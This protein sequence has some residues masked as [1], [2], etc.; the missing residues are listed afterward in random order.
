MFQ[1]SLAEI[2]LFTFL[3]LPS[4]FS[5]L[6]ILEPVFA[7]MNHS[8]GFFRL[9]ACRLNGFL[10]DTLIV[11]LQ[12]LLLFLSKRYTLI[13][14]P[15]LPIFACILCGF[16]Q[17][18]I[19]LDAFLYKGAKLRF[20]APFFAFANDLGCFWDSAKE[21]GI[22]L[23]Y[24]LGVIFFAFVP[25]GF[26]KIE[27]AAD[28][29]FINPT[30]FIWYSA[31][32]FL[33]VFCAIFLP[34]KLC[35]HL[36]NAFFAQLV[37]VLKKF[38]TLI[39]RKYSFTKAKNLS[40]K[41]IFTPQN[42]KYSSVSSLYPLLKYTNG[43]TGEKQCDVDVDTS[44]RPH[45]I[46]LFMES[47]RAKDVGV[48]QGEQSVTPHFD[49]LSKEGILFSNFYANSVKTSR[50][51]TAS[52]FGIPSDVNSSEISSRINM[53]FISL[54]HILEKSGYE[55]TYHHNGLLEFE[56]QQSFFTNYGYKNLVGR[57]DILKKYPN[58]QLT[59]W[60][61]HDEY[62]MKYS[63]DWLAEEDKK[64]KPVFLTMFTISNHHPWSSPK[65]YRLK[66]L[67]DKLDP[68]YKR[69]LTT[70]HYSDLCLKLFIDRLKKNNL[71][72]KTVLFIL[73]DH[74]HPMG[75]HNKN[76]IEQRYLYEE[77]IHVPLLIYA[78]GRI[79]EPKI[80]DD[81]SSQ[82]DLIPTVMDMLKI[83]GLNHARGST[84]LR[85]ANRQVF[86]HNPYVYRFYGTRKG[87]H[88]LIYTKSS[89][90]VELYDLITDPREQTNIAYKYP[91]I[92]ESYLEDVKNYH[93]YYQS[94][95]DNKLFSPFEMKHS[96]TVVDFSKMNR[97]SAARLLNELKK[98]PYILHLDLS[99]CDLL[100]DST[101]I[102]MIKK[103]KE[104]RSLN[105]SNCKNLTKASLDSVAS[106]C[107]RLQFIDLSFCTFTEKEIDFFIKKGE[108][109]ES[110]I[111]KDKDHLRSV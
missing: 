58:A 95:Y 78:E 2:L 45:V 57:N 67:P 66:H 98:H 42:E 99:S 37:W 30:F 20:E 86:F 97:L 91:E 43:F 101:F 44:D 49:A 80:I 19:L 90:E 94:L 7:K 26:Y 79:K 6:L 51:V 62:L 107:E 55:S 54:A 10:Q 52:L 32:S 53:P 85:K 33:S 61:V 74:G 77:N 102:E 1:L 81:V 9:V 96:P 50:S 34:K 108:H 29:S 35:Y 5:R 76:Y 103:H 27:S 93:T 31:I 109:L 84:L 23:L 111:R 106:Y 60:G 104:I 59:S 18:D 83:K 72:K 71:S 87:S 40:S 100:D 21:R 24:P 36:E 82:I 17:L 8:R 14:K 11:L 47:L 88:K 63:A 92:V 75:E 12:I 13:S 4:L 16:I 89:K 15:V 28:F 41:K 68:I 70:T 65:G 3:F 73:G 25:I 39:I 69:Y 64:G 46:F 56:N 48:L 38:F 110:V 22:A 105:V